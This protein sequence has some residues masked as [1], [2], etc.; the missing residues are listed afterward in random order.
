[1]SL[2]N[3]T[4]NGLA[5]QPVIAFRNSST[6]FRYVPEFAARFRRLIRLSSKSKWVEPICKR[7]Q[8][9]PFL[10]RLLL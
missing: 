1:M 10:F 5:C 7:Y 2:P 3:Y 9:R 6:M 8:L 4:A